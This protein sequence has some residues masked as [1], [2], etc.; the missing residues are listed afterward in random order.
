MTMVDCVDAP[1]DPK[2]KRIAALSAELARTKSQI[3]RYDADLAKLRAIHDELELESVELARQL[4]NR[5]GCMD[6]IN[7]AKARYESSKAQLE[8]WS[9]VTERDL[10]TW[11]QAIDK[12]KQRNS[13]G[14]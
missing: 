7:S 9:R 4:A 6:E 10:T 5:S 2:D 8:G 13:E 12:Q 1:D 11:L 3:E 14:K